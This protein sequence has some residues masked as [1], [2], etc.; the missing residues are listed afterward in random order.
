MRGQGR[1]GSRAASRF[2]CGRFGSGERRGPDGLDQSQDIL[3]LA[4]IG[5]DR[6]RQEQTGVDRNRQE[7][8]RIDRNRQEQKGSAEV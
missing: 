8:T 7:Q 1:A 3:T 2:I 5:A 4:T 6:N